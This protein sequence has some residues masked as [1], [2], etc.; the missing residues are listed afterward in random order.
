[1]NS[2][3]D[4]WSMNV[5]ELERAR[6]EFEHLIDNDSHCCSSTV[7]PA[8]A[9]LP[10]PPPPPLQQHTTTTTTTTTD[11][12][13]QDDAA[14]T[15]KPNAAP[16]SPAPTDMNSSTRHSPPMTAAST[17]TTTTGSSS[18]LDDD[19][20]SSFVDHSDDAADDDEPC[21]MLLTNAARRFRELELTLLEA[22]RDSDEAVEELIHLWTTER[23]ELAAHALLSLQSGRYECSDG[24]VAEEVA[25]TALCR[26][27][28]GWAE[29]WTRLATLLCCK[30]R[31]EDA[32]SAAEEAASV[33]PWHFEALNVGALVLTW[34][35][36]Q[37]Q[38]QQHQ[39]QQ[40]QDQSHIQ[41][42]HDLV[43][44]ATRL[45]RQRLPPLCP[46]TGH[47]ARR[48]WVDHAVA[49][50]TSQLQCAEHVLQART[51]SEYH[52]QR[53]AAAAF[54]RKGG[55][56]VTAPPPPPQPSNNTV[57]GTPLPPPPPTTTTHWTST[58][59]SGSSTTTPDCEI[60]Q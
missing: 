37:Q 2:N 23:H 44:R 59:A 35:Q 28:P 20:A 16:W 27:H 17:R 58:T 32:L 24:L 1:L 29:P 50:A 19:S 8:G 13:N 12:D 33:K 10:P 22:L 3:A 60:W 53:N 11:Q 26:T 41:T 42:S 38:Q 5:Y 45:A 43:T 52:H 7:Q 36:Q 56:V 48:A 30:G 21:M 51:A 40:H 14:P 18:M 47:A 25:L 9:I 15:S 54:A 39:Q 49:L 4:D 55:V 57:I 34:V 46:S 31:M 6:S